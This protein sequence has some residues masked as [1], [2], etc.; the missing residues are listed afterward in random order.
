MKQERRVDHDNKST[1]I[2]WFDQREEVRYQSGTFEDEM[3]WFK[4][5]YSDLIEA[6]RRSKGVSVSSTL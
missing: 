6:R 3:R 1:R 5:T 2:C 4:K